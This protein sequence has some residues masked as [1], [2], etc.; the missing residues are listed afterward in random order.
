MHLFLGLWFFFCI[1]S[2]GI[3]WFL[4]GVLFRFLRP[5]HHLLLRLRHR[6]IWSA[7]SKKEEATLIQHRN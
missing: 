5:F 3:R 4:L 2:L 6:S 7:A 1:S